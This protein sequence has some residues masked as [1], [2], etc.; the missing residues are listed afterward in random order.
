MEDYSALMWIAGGLFLILAEFV[1]PGFIVCFFGVSAILT[2]ILL[3]IFPS[4]PVWFVFFF[5][6]FMSVALIFLSRKIMPETFCGRT[7]R[8]SFDPD[9]DEVEGTKAQVLETILPGVP[10]KVDYRGSLWEAES[11]C[12]HKPGELVTVVKRKNLTL[13]VR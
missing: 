10:G 7:T 13:V 9:G 12:E 1:I 6:S 11:D 4:I 5:F 8:E 3:E 2:G